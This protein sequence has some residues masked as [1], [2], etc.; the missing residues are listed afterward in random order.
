M[1]TKLSNGFRNMK[2]FE[3]STQNTV[4]SSLNVE[5]D[6][7]FPM[8]FKVGSIPPLQGIRLFNKHLEKRTDNQMTSSVSWTLKKT[9]TISPS[10]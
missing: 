3:L 2:K 6:C 1:R 7:F 4:F 8:I 5:S 9:F 10:R